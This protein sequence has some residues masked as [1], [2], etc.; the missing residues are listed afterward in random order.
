[1]AT[2]PPVVA[3]AA[4]A[5]NAQTCR[6][7]VGPARTT[8]ATSSKDLVLS[9]AAATWTQCA[10]R[11]LKERP[12]AP[13][14]VTVHLAFIDKGFRSATCAACPSALAACIQATRPPVSLNIRG[15]DITGEPSFDV[16]LTITCD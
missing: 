3:P 10:Q 4:P 13:L 12:S 8:G 15:G 5:F 6:A 11:S 16:P 14:A 1:V 2:P 9:N 7:S